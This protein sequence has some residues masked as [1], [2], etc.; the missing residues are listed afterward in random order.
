MSTTSANKRVIPPIR[1]NVNRQPQVSDAHA[2]GVVAIMAPKFPTD[3]KRPTMVANSFFLNHRENA[4]IAGVYIPPMPMPIN[5]L[6]MDAQPIPGAIPKIKHT[7][8][9]ENH[10]PVEIFTVVSFIFA[11]QILQGNIDERA[12]LARCE[13]GPL[14]ISKRKVF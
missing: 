5:A 6:P 3:I 9:K 11:H 13:E 12:Q 1:K 14:R 10:P 2:R 8:C 7:D 4:F